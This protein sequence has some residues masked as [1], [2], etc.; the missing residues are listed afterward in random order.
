MGSK[1]SLGERMK[2]YEAVS[3]TRLV[4][5]TPVIVRVDGRAF[6][7]LTRGFEKPW[8]RT[9]VRCMEDV[10]TALCQELAGARLAYVQSD[11]VSVLLVDY[12]SLG[13]EAFF[14]NQVQKIVSVAASIATVAFNRSMA[15][16][17]RD[18]AAGATFDARAFNVPREEVCNYFLWRQQDAVRNSIQGLGQA[19]FSP[20]ELHGV[21]CDGIQELLF[22]QKGINWSETP[23]HLKRGL[24]VVKS[25]RD[26]RG[27]LMGG[28]IWRVDREPPVFSQ[29]RSY[30]ERHVYPQAEA[31][32]PAS[33]QPGPSGYDPEGCL[34]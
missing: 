8:D 30:V 2:E 23:T 22:Q 5:R 11:E 6:H 17:H 15:L 27:Y 18:Y 7:T 34:R 10:A 1:D 32:R 25:D 14:D 26:S 9:F 28:A 33:A 29:D 24:C 13:T 16:Y 4:R 31:E 3:R 20:K 21:S 19:H 12:Q